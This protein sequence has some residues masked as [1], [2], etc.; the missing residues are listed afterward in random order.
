MK[1]LI[2]SIDMSQMLSAS[3]WDIMTEAVREGISEWQL[4]MVCSFLFVYDK[5]IA[6]ARGIVKCL[7]KKIAPVN[8]FFVVLTY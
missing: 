7:K 8:N 1:P 2:S 4:N 5:N 6:Y 3:A